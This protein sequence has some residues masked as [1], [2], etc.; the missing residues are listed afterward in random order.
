MKNLLFLHDTKF[1]TPRGAELTI[2]QLMKLG[3]EKK[4][5]IESDLLRDFELT[6]EKIRLSDLI[7]VNS[8]SRCRYEIELI[9][10][11][12]QEKI[13]YIKIEFD[14]NF[15]IRRNIHCTI[16]R[17][18]ARCCN[19][20]KFHHFRELFK[21]SYLNIFQSP[22]HY[23]SHFEFYGEAV[24]NYIIMPPTVEVGNLKISEL[25]NEKIIP[26]F[27]SLNIMKGGNAYLD[28]AEQ[29]PELEF[30]VYGA[31]QLNRAIPKNV[32]FLAPISNEEVLEILGKTKTF[33]CM[34]DW[35]EPSGRLAAEAF[36]SGCEMMINDRVGT[37][38]FDF[39]KPSKA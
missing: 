12:I 1:D 24:N 19:P 21:H 7:I 5:R 33:I 13:N 23:K 22:A 14:Y 9:Q 29:H 28:Y 27:G 8:T 4:F 30:H 36:L 18:V 39:F 37:F 2:L 10:F 25:K 16:T 20:D 11:L 17:N 15:C 34:P 35:P 38:S 3:T 26:F 6:K 32:R 31:N